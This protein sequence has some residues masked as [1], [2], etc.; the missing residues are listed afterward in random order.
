MKIAYYLNLLVWEQA[1]EL[2]CQVEPKT[3]YG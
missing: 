2:I 1:V 3:Y